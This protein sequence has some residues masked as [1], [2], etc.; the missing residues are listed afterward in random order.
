MTGQLS[1]FPSPTGSQLKAAG[2]KKAVVHADQ[3]VDG[4]SAQAYSFL[5]DFIRIHEGEFMAEDVR[6]KSRGIVPVPPTTRAWGSIIRS[7]AM[8]GLIRKVR[9]T[10][11]KNPTAH[12]A[13]AA[14]WQRTTNG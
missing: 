5:V 2:M 11:V 9:I 8:S 3:V 13:N 6:E 12:S 1:I 14:V 4:W 7:A 10:T